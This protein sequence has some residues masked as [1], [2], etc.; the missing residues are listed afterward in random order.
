M[1]SK[2]IKLV[3]LPA[4][5]LTALVF[6]GYQAW[7]RTPP[8][9]PET[10]DDV[11]AL[12]T[13]RRYA[14]L[15]NT[16]KRPYQERMNEM[17]GSLSKED[18]KWLGEQLKDNPDARQEAMEQGIRTMYRTMII[19]QDEAARNAMLDMIIN[20]MESAEGRQRR[21]DDQARRDTP[22]GKKQ[23]EEGRRRMMDWLDKGDPQ[24]M[25]Y[26]SEF[27]KMLQDRRKERGLPPF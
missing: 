13:S 17:W 10:A 4:L 26:G 22:E 6:G 21:Q 15:S 27:F 24:T 14:R 5:A 7:L 19:Q 1:K 2:L 8:A 16:D 20:Q 12:L 9:M 25:G 23:E 18:R 11:E 3:L